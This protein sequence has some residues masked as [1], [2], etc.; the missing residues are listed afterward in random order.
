MNKI[1]SFLILYIVLYLAALGGKEFS[2]LLGITKP[3]NDP[4]WKYG[5]PAAISLVAAIYFSFF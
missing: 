4:Y 2:V 5:L 3:E 1:L